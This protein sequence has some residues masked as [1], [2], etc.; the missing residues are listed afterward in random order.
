MAQEFS[1][2]SSH[3]FTYSIRRNR[4]GMLCFEADV[5][6]VFMSLKTMKSIPITDEFRDLFERYM[7]NLIFVIPYTKTNNKIGLFY[8]VVRLG[9]LT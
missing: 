4:D 1:G 6:T 9:C 5:T 3:I 7:E 8:V 2:G